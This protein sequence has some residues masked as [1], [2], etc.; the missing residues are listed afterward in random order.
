MDSLTGCEKRLPA[1]I[2]CLP[3][4]R[5]QPQ[6]KADILGESHLIYQNQST[7]VFQ[8]LLRASGGGSRESRESG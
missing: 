4:P 6:L 2:P 7:Q 5:H 3:P 8:D 1:P